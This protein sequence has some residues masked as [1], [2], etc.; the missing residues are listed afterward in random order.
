M[1]TNQD[2]YKIQTI[3]KQTY[4]DKRKQTGHLSWKSEIKN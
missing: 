1:P 2:I 4:G 3:K